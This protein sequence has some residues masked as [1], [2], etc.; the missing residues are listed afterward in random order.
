MESQNC[1]ICT[2]LNLP[3]L[4][5]HNDLRFITT[6]A[7]INSSF[8]IIVES[9]SIIW[10]YYNLFIHSS[11]DGHGLFPNLANKGKAAINIC[12]QVFVQTYDFILLDKLEGV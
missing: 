7:C 12:V 10:R 9:Y 1:T 2:L 6:I 4:A 3:S 11:T 8:L 5:Q